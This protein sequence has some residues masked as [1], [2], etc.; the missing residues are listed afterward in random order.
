MWCQFVERWL[1]SIFDFARVRQRHSFPIHTRI[2]SSAVA[3]LIR[4]R[5]ASGILPLVNISEF[6]ANRGYYYRKY[7]PLGWGYYHN[8]ASSPKHANLEILSS[9]ISKHEALSKVNYF[10]RISDILCL[11]SKG[12]ANRS[13]CYKDS[14]I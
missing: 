1:D 12:F 3:F 7:S 13:I 14:S 9:S 4:L 11:N 5:R 8:L 2:Y 6:T 10:T